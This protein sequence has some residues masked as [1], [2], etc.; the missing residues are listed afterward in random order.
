MQFSNEGERL[1]E[2]TFIFPLP[3]GAAVDQLTMWVDGQAIDAKILRA[4]EAR[5]IYNEIVR[6]Y[7]DPALLEYIG[8]DMIQANIFPIPPGDTRRIQIRYGQALTV[9]NGLINYT[10]PMKTT[11]DR[12][13]KEMSIS[14]SVSGS[15]PISN[16][17]SPSH[18]IAISR[19]HNDDTSFTAGFEASNYRPESDFSLFY[20]IATDTINVNLLTYRESANE[21]GF[22]MLMVQPPVEV[23]ADAVI[24][25]D[26]IVVLDQSGSMDGEKWDQARDA[27]GLVLQHLN[28]RDRF[29]LIL[30]STG[31]RLFSNSMQNP[32]QADAAINWIQ[33]QDAAGGTDI[34]GALLS[35]FDMVGE[36][37]T[38]ILFLTDGLA[39][40]GETET[41][42][43]LENLKQSAPPNV[44]VFTFGVGYDVDTFLLDAIV[45]DHHGTGSYVRPGERI[46]EKVES[47]Y[48]KVSAP[49][50]NDIALDFGSNMNVDWVYPTE[51]PDLFAGEQ[52][53]LV[54]RYRGSADN[55]TIRLSGSVGSQDMNFVYNG[56]DFPANAGGQSF[57]AR[58]WA[59][60]RIGD[61]LNTIRLNGENSEL[62]DSVVN[63]SVRYGI[64]TPYTSFL[65]EENDIL[66]QEGLDRVTAGFAEEAEALSTQNTGAGAVAAAD[67]SMRLQSAQSVAAA[68]TASAMPSALPGDADG[69][70][71]NDELGAAPAVNP[72]QSVGDKTF[73]LQDGVWTDTTFQPDTMQTE[74]VEF[75][76]D[77]Y[78]DLLAQHPELGEYFAL[79]E[80]VIVVLDGTAYEVVPA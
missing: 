56:N 70:L 64:I 76:G 2:G 62:V 7:R 54:G 67:A 51:L 37:P 6:Q 31:W 42:R 25:K 27:A 4:G 55:V 77:A 33:G 5:G 57:I 48:N 40:E 1:A 12:L 45:R 29:N 75:L 50:L 17:Y 18:P 80:Q 78:F 65:I 13:V 38:T 24:P 28:S 53:T 73:L 47:L 71:H 69:T 59:T 15:D 8:S 11:G 63:L 39:T 36:R 72:V 58:L 14:V 22:F 74:K 52:L 35:A 66:T 3:Q 44:S 68:P 79:G 61:L 30:F 21:D 34:N 32:D 19:A 49:V 23:D 20:G 26:V 10:Y 41:S 16:I 43:I 60:R 9:D 46:D